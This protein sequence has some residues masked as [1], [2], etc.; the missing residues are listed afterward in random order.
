MFVGS[1][2]TKDFYLPLGA[3]DTGGRLFLVCGAP[4]V[5]L[6]S[7]HGWAAADAVG[8]VDQSVIDAAVAGEKKQEEKSTKL[9]VVSRWWPA[10]SN[11]FW[12]AVQPAGFSWGARL[13]CSASLSNDTRKA[14]TNVPSPLSRRSDRSTRASSFGPGIDF[15]DS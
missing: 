6:V 5:P 2:D 1:L 12:N 10:F 3:S 4:L 9:A 8:L 7:G 14:S 11:R 13:N 15:L